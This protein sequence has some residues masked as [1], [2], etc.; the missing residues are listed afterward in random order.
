MSCFYSLIYM[1]IRSGGYLLVMVYCL[2]LNYSRLYYITLGV[3]NLQVTC[4]Q[5]DGLLVCAFKNYAIWF[6]M[7]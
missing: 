1:I 6:E 3:Y 5:V 2:L 4:L 7:L